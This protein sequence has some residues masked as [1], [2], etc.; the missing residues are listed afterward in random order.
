MRTEN[1]EFP[2]AVRFLADDLC[3]FRKLG[4]SHNIENIDNPGYDMTTNKVLC[5]CTSF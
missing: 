3:R 4:L 1:L 2:E 5:P